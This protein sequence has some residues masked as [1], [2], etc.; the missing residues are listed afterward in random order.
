MNKLRT[1]TILRAAAAGGVAMALSLAPGTDANAAVTDGGGGLAVRGLDISAYQHAGSAI[2]WGL[3]P[4][5]GISFVGIKVSEG[6]YYVNPFYSS[7]ARNA[8]AAG[9]AVFP[10]VFANPSRVG[11]PATANFAVRTVGRKHRRLPLVVDLEND[12][13]NRHADCYGRSRP[14]IIAWIAG[15]TARAKALT[16]S[17]PVIYTT[18]DWWRECTGATGQFR[19]DP[20]WLAAFDGTAPTVPSPWHDWTFWQYNDQGRLAGVGQS[21][22]DYYQPTSDLPTLRPQ[23]KAPQKKAPQKKA[24]QKKA[25]PQQKKPSEKKHGSK[26]KPKP[27]PKQKKPPQKRPEYAGKPAAPAKSKAQ[28]MPRK[29]TLRRARPKQLRHPAG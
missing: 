9:L 13:Y 17:Y 22:L 8:T 29:R 2:D 20:L 24:P 15:F 16:G 10:Y 23:K 6:D 27:K 5:Q 14:A 28:P 21:D 25:R 12:P 26:P 18:A 4:G 3:L 1:V 19:R 11:G 7:D